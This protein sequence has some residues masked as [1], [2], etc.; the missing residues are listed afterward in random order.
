M[1]IIGLCSPIALLGVI[2]PI[3]VC[4][5]PARADDWPQWLGPN[6]DGVWRETGLLDHFPAGGPHVRW[7]G[8]G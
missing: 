2:I 8:Q 5:N 7:R 6:R 1:R 3:A 4:S